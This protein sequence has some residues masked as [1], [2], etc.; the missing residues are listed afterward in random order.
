MSCARALCGGSPPGML[1]R[2]SLAGL[3]VNSAHRQTW[4][5]LLA[6]TAS[7]EHC[8]TYH[9][10]LHGLNCCKSSGRPALTQAPG[11]HSP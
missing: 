2:V 5:A 11:I 4:T 3:R 8:K 7:N 1:A 10:Q 9:P 6:P